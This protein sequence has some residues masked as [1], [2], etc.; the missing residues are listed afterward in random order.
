MYPNM[1]PE[2]NSAIEAYR[3][4]PEFLGLE[5]LDVNQHGALDATLLHLAVRAGNVS[6]VTTLIRYGARVNEVGDMGY[7]ALHDAAERGH[8]EI[9][10][11]LLKAGANP[12]LLNEWSRTAL[13]LARE[14]GNRKLVALLSK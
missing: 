11:V 5:I 12:K 10:E 8:V 7:T 1:Q 2:L 14:T 13:D 9:V 3:S 6:H 4:H